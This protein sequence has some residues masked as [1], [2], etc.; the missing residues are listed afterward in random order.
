MSKEL[1]IVDENKFDNPVF[2]VRRDT[3]LDCPSKKLLF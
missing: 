3:Q 2:D 1:S